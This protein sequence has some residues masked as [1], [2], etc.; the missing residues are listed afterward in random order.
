MWQI[1]WKFTNIYS[2]TRR[3]RLKSCKKMLISLNV[4][5]MKW[6]IRH[7][8]KQLTMFIQLLLR[9]IKV[10][11]K[12]VRNWNLFWMSC[13]KRTK[14]FEIWKWKIL[15]FNL[16]W[17]K[18]KSNIF[19]ENNC[20]KHLNPVLMHGKETYWHAKEKILVPVWKKE[21]GILK[22]YPLQIKSTS[23]FI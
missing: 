3:Q 13:K 17:M 2:K 16:L 12:R 20:I 14:L 19:K 18:G 10:Q 21:G 7:W 9:R 22:K 8:H 11:R 15:S 1:K 4:T 23:C 6:L 5:S